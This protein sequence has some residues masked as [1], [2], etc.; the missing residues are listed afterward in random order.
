MGYRAVQTYLQR[1]CVSVS[2]R[3]PC[4][5]IQNC[6]YMS[7]MGDTPLPRTFRDFQHTTRT[8]T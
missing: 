3:L 7:V 6:V 2:C 4:P 5:S 1:Q 8:S